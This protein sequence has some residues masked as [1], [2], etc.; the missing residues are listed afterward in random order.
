MSFESHPIQL[1]P[2]SIKEKDGQKYLVK[3]KADLAV[4]PLSDFEMRI[5]KYLQNGVSLEKIILALKDIQGKTKLTQLYDFLNKLCLEDFI[6][7]QE[8]KDFFILTNEELPK[9]EDIQS[10]PSLINSLGRLK[11]SFSKQEIHSHAQMILNQEELSFT[12]RFFQLPFIRHLPEESHD[13]IIENSN[14]VRVEAGT[15]LIREGEETRELIVLVEGKLGLYK[16]NQDRQK[17]VY[18]TS[19][20]PGAVLGEGGFFLGKKRTASILALTDVKVVRVR[21]VDGFINKQPN[22][23]QYL[24]FQERIWY[25]QAMVASPYFKFLPPDAFDLFMRLGEMKWF[26]HSDVVF[27]L[28][29]PSE[30]LGVIV[31]GSVEAYSDGKVIR[32]MGAGDV[33]GEIG[34]LNPHRKR[35]LK[36]L[37]GD[38]TLICEIPKKRLWDFFSRNFILAVEFEKLALSRLKDHPGD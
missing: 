9:L 31:Q 24:Q 32:T 3:D 28:G 2:H 7:N 15:T 14:K 23:A 8:I 16:Y 34:I 18:V 30:T 38:K 12:D 6:T 33:I 1:H 21:F 35:S 17:H 20:S 29:D 26:E 5:L 13:L 19:F 4:L 10:I 36:L 37:S 25:L 22:S 27:K 11:E